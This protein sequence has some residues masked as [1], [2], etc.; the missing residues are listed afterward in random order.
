MG[1]VIKARSCAWGARAVAAVV[2]AKHLVWAVGAG[3]RAEVYA[4]G[5]RGA[6]AMAVSTEAW[7]HMRGLSG[8]RFTRV[9][10]ASCLALRCFRSTWDQG[11]TT[12]DPHMAARQHTL[13]SL[14][15]C[16][17]GRFY[18]TCTNL[19]IYFLFPRR[20]CEIRLQLHDDQ[21]PAQHFTPPTSAL[22]AC[23]PGRRVR[24]AA[25]LAL[26]GH[27]PGYTFALRKRSGAQRHPLCST[28]HSHRT[29]PL[30]AGLLQTRRA[31][32]STK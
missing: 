14:C 19:Q 3:I 16:D 28:A 26:A 1:A 20:M 9:S 22:A 17:L 18:L 10:A 21:L 25:G 24:V 4:C 8:V 27:A 23:C 30:P 7:D 6:R 15:A 31:Q 2:R 29:H 13:L 11:R 32:T 12:L 5:V